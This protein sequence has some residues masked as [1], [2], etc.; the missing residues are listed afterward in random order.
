MKLRIVRK[1][2][3]SVERTVYYVQKK[4]LWFWVNL[5]WFSSLDTAIEMR[6]NWNAKII[7]EAT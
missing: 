5:D 2:H 7:E 6:D 1:W 3:P 4:F